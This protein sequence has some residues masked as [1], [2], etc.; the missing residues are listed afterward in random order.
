VWLF[1][2]CALEIVPLVGFRLVVQ[3]EVDGA[4]GAVTPCRSTGHY[5]HIGCATPDHDPAS[6]VSCL[7][8]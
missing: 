5:E 7:A 4:D 3:K 8:I 1:E 6:S 2:S